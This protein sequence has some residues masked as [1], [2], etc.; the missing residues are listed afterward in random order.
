[1]PHIIEQI[2]PI[3][4]AYILLQTRNYGDTKSLSADIYPS[5]YDFSDKAKD[6]FRNILTNFMLKYGEK[7]E[8]G[9]IAILGKR[10]IEVNSGNRNVIVK[11]QTEIRTFLYDLNNY[12][13]EFKGKTYPATI[14][15][16]MVAKYNFLEK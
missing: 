9:S 16:K 1:M 4:C 11:L 15:K 10:T 13:F 6:N 14:I 2:H 7:I 8:K 5:Y 3:K 12:I